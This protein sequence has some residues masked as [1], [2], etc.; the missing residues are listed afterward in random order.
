MWRVRVNM[1]W[2]SVLAGAALISAVAVTLVAGHSA[3]AVDNGTIGIRPATESDFF[4]LSLFPGAA[5]EEVA[6]VSN[7]SPDAITL[8]LYAVDG[9]G[10]PQGTFAFGA[11]SDE[12]KGVGAWVELDRH[13]VTVP[14][15]SEIPVQFRLTV[16][17][18]T[19]PGDYAGGLII[20][21][22]PV[23][24]EVADVGDG[25]AVRVDVVQ[26]QGLRIYLT[27]AGEAIQ[28]L[29]AGVLT[30]RASGDTMRFSLPL[31][32]TGNTIVRPTGELDLAGWIGVNERVAFTVPESILPGGSYT[33][34]AEV[35]APLVHWGA[36]RAMVMSEAGD[37]D[38]RVDVVFIPRE[39]VAGVIA[40]IV[41][42]GLVLWRVA[43]FVRRARRAFAQLDR[44]KPAGEPAHLV[45]TRASHSSR[46]SSVARASHSS[47]AKSS[48][49]A[50]RHRRS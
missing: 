49:R 13:E 1:G 26:R 41:V 47:R 50:P 36:A 5:L 16:P 14:A 29:E 23:V 39:L 21:E 46:A 9:E 3:S 42:G 20:Q 44:S 17:T 19:P 11:Q 12:R 25:T 32:N 37:I 10:T 22:P 43:R 28:R 15:R 35:S 45:P 6:I 38:T 30:W 2:A 33:M 18:G 48:S 40:L 7:R 27:V 34:E 8:L 24:G 4:H 31:T